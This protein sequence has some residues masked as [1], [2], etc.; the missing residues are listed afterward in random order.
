M[1]KPQRSFSGRGCK[2]NGPCLPLSPFHR[3]TQNLSELLWHPLLT[4]AVQI[5]EPLAES[6]QKHV[7]ALG[8][9]PHHSALSPENFLTKLTW[10]RSFLPIFF[11]WIYLFSYYTPCWVDNSLFAGKSS[12]LSG[13][14]WED[15]AL[16]RSPDQWAMSWPISTA[17]CSHCGKKA[18]ERT[19]LCIFR[20]WPLRQSWT[21]LKC[22]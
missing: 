4:L 20:S 16:N 18:L 3:A 11:C 15:Q 1:H 5:S 7:T 12:E 17:L 13:S 22:Q 9:L 14:S 21:E 8:Q 6:A 2:G 19:R 10:T